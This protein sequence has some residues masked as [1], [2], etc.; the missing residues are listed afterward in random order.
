M[1]GVAGIKYFSK[2]SSKLLYSNIEM[3]L[4]T[5]RFGELNRTGKFS[6]NFDF[7]A[8]YNICNNVNRV[9][10]SNKHP[11][12][13][14]ILHGYLTNSNQYKTEI[15]SSENNLADIIAHAYIKY[16]LDFVKKLQGIFS[17][18]IYD[19]KRDYIHIGTDRYGYGYIFYYLDNER[20]I[21]GSSIKPILK[22]LNNKPEV[23]L[24]GIC[25][26]H[27]YHTVYNQDTPFKNVYLLP[28]A[29]IYSIKDDL[30]IKQYWE[31]PSG[32]DFLK[33]ENNKLLESA[34]DKIENAVVPLTTDSD[35]LGVL[36]TGGLDSRL[37]SAVASKHISREN[38]YLFHFFSNKVEKSI[39]QQIADHLKC[40]IIFLEPSRKNKIDQIKGDI[41]FSDGHWGFYDFTGYFEDIMEMYPGISLMNG[42]YMD[43]LFK[44]GFAFFPQKVDIE[45]IDITDFSRRFRFLGENLTNLIF[46]PDFAQMVNSNRL[47]RIEE[48][49]QKLDYNFPTELSIRFYTINR[50][51]RSIF[52]SS[53]I[54]EHYTKI[55]FPGVDY[56]LVDFAFRIPY[57]YRS[58]TKF[59]REIINSWFPEI[60]AIPWIRTGQPL[61]EDENKRANNHYSILNRYQYYLQRAT[62]GIIDLRNDA[63]SFNRMFRR[64]KNFRNGINDILYD[65]KTVERGFF[66]KH[67]VDLLVKQQL[68]GRDYSDLF[69][70]ILTVEMMFREFIDA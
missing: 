58:N 53:K 41:W 15:N 46:T 6:N 43:T 25:D 48:A 52:Y 2:V 17:F 44:S 59:Y 64:N 38:F 11:D 9:H 33:S 39:V 19:K 65:K 31:F 1:S 7:A 10:Y 69:Q 55:V 63:N 13:I 56:N 60:G 50:G 66:D 18:V 37:L 30:R 12:I 70:S 32:P 34:K 42:Y 22:I 29:A 21:F 16:E 54:F 5:F 8:G 57:I 26:I 23:N 67:G 62:H 47:K 51:R 45:N 27:N 3:M 61:S 4:K 14:V 40:R 20:F 68:S 24:A 35:K 36:I 49:H 28:I